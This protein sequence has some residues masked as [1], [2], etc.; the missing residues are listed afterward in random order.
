MK[1]LKT[2]LI[3]PLAGLLAMPVFA[4]NYHDHDGYSRFDNRQER[5]S[6]RIRKGVKSG[7]L[8]RY[9]AK[10]LRKQQK[11]IANLSQ[12][13]KRDG[14]LSRHE[15][16]KLERRQDAASKKIAGLKH[17]DN[18]RRGSHHHHGKGKHHFGKNRHISGYR[19]LNTRRYTSHRRLH[20]NDGWSL[21]LRLSDDF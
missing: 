6:S 20:D 11:E 5:Q 15:R 14:K 16:Q 18:Y 8:T 10:K 19:H 7:E 12:K 2:L 21:I 13:L 9:E 1:I 17:N 3:M 4:H